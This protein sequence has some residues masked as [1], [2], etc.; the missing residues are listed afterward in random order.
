M[1]DKT[2]APRTER[3]CGGRMDQVARSCECVSFAACSFPR[4][5][6]SPRNVLLLWRK[7]DCETDGCTSDG[8]HMFK[9]TGSQ[10]AKALCAHAFPISMA[11][12]MV[13]GMELYNHAL[14]SGELSARTLLSPFAE[15]IPM[16]IAVLVVEGLLGGR[17]VAQILARIGG[18]ERFN[19]SA[20]VLMGFVTCVV[21]CPLMSMVATLV[22]K[23]PTFSTVASLWL[24][25]FVRN[26]PFALAWALLVARPLSGTVAERLGKPTPAFA[27]EA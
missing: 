18:P 21:M 19:I 16:A 6:L 8:A 23:H 15:L 1:I 5:R 24:G 2:L 27:V 7:S 25:T 4:A 11:L 10:P 20:G 12:L 26:L 14:M 9:K 17:I 22:F 13:Y 3:N